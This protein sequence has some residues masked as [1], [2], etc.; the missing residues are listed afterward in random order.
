MHSSK[1][2]T[3]I[4]CAAIVFT[5]KAQNI[6]ALLA[7][8][9]ITIALT[10]GQWLLKDS[11]KV[12]YVRVESIAL[13]PAQAR[14]EGFKLAV[15]QAVGT[16]IVAESEVK[17]QQLVR[18]EIV[19]YSSGYIQDFKILNETQVGSMTRVVM[20]VWVTESKIADRLLSVSKAD[21]VIE[22]EKSAAQFQNNLSQHQSGDKLLGLILRDFP[23]KAFDL[24]VGKVKVAMQNRDVQIQIPVK[25]SWNKEY[26]GALTEAL[27]KT[28][29][30]QGF[31]SYKGRPWAAVIRYK[32]KSDWFMS[33]ASFRDGYK[34]GL[35]DEAL[36][37]SH[38][39]VRLVIKNDSGAVQYDKCYRYRGFMATQYQDGQNIRK[40]IADSEK[41]T[42]R[43]YF[44]GGESPN[45]QNDPPDL[46]IFGDLSDEIYFDLNIPSNLAKGF[47]EQS[48]KVEVA[49]VRGGQCN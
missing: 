1:A 43:F 38:P 22:G 28:R 11:Q 27:D 4:L 47:L 20:D 17:N 9:P 7:P 16:L 21:G 46:S 8:N 44:R 45:N 14:A 49:V 48:N 39:L 12:Y 34:P 32:N 5:A 13:T 26:I 33:T 37:Q 18:S 3:F 24:Q 30:G 2:A 15:S 36:I 42:G 40:P 41:R 35:L 31:N 25:I 23:T 6:A 19:Q 10:V 29:D